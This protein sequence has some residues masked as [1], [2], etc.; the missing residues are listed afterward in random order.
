M[1]L[2]YLLKKTYDNLFIYITCSLLLNIKNKQIIM[3]AMKIIGIIFVSY[4]STLAEETKG[5]S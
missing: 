4:L 2:I 1:N 3:A 5:Q